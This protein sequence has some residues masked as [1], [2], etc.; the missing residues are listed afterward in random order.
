MMQS[1]ANL[2][3]PA[4]PRKP[5]TRQTTRTF[6]QS[7]DDVRILRLPEKRNLA[8]SLSDD[9]L[10]RDQNECAIK[11]EKHEG[12]CQVA[13]KTRNSTTAEVLR[14]KE[15]NSELKH[16]AETQVAVHDKHLGEILALKDKLHQQE[17]RFQRDRQVWQHKCE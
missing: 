12:N 7:R 6:V 2:L 9:D 10:V 14:L 15:S 13:D 16:Q 3:S 5:Q 1:I 4:Q 17:A 11:T 8:E